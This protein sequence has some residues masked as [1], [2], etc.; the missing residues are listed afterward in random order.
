MSPT[1]P[2]GKSLP[3]LASSFPVFQTDTLLCSPEAVTE[4][5]MDGEGL[6]T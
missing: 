2:V 6:W 1:V 4:H 3:A 5:G